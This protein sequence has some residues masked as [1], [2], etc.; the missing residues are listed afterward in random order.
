M[1]AKVTNFFSDIHKAFLSRHIYFPMI[2][3]KLDTQL[4]AHIQKLKFAGESIGFVP[5]MGA[6]HEGHIQ[7]VKEAIKT[8]DICV[9]SIFVNPTQ[10]NIK[11]DL[12]NYPVT[13]SADIELLEKN[14]CHILYLPSE[15]VIYPTNDTQKLSYDIGPIEHLLEGAFR[16]GHYKGV[17][18]VVNIL[19][20]TLMPDILLL[21]AKDY[22]QCKVLTQFAAKHYPDMK[23]RMVATVR[24]ES[25]LALSSRNKR[26]SAEELEIAPYI[27][28]CLLNIKEQL[29]DVDLT[30]LENEAIST[31][32]KSGLQP[33]YVVIANA[34][35]LEKVVHWDGETK[36]V[37]LVAAKLGAVR[38]I[39]NLELN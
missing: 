25:G 32:I 8:S 1:F 38:L 5:T 24:A 4:Q 20:K 9:V 2:I 31:L 35:N 6:L 33:E 3:F 36:L 29:Q 17:V 34:N 26:L 12:I 16:P 37:A 22:Q 15:E 10:F 11:E 19:L 39:D 13:T 27:Y 18:Q 30:D 14:G 7:L 28:K 21:G 23:V